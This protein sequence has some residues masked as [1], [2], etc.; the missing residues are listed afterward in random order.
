MRTWRRP[1][2]T[3]WQRSPRT[4]GPARTPKS[5]IPTACR[6]T[7]RPPSRPRPRSRASRASTL[8]LVDEL[9]PVQLVPLLARLPEAELRD[10]VERS[11]VVRC[12]RGTEPMDAVSAA[13]PVE[14][15]ADRL[16]PIAMPA[17]LWQQ[18][19]ADL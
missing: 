7:S 4:S 10:Q 3:P 15:G 13:G 8:Q 16:D 12:H 11:L 6:P 1:S 9:E 2:A 5:A 17:R 14:R 19:V 18:G